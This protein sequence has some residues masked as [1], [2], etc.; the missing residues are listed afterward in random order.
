MKKLLVAT[1][2]ALGLMVKLERER[3]LHGVASDRQPSR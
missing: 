3:R 2:L 1:L